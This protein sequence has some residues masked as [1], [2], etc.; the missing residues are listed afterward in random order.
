MVGKFECHKQN[1]DLNTTK[2]DKILNEVLNEIW[3]RQ[4]I[5]WWKGFTT[6]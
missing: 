6:Q 5:M 1:I 2:Y 4:E 3:G